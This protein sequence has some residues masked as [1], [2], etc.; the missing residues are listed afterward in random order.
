MVAKHCHNIDDNKSQLL[1]EFDHFSV[2]EKLAS[3]LSTETPK[4]IKFTEDLTRFM[5]NIVFYIIFLHVKKDN[6]IKTL[7]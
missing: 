6:K 5:T 3:P 4:Y 1:Q 7:P 2:V